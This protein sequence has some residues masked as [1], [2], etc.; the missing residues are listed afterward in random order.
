[1]E[2]F[3]GK[4]EDEEME[5]GMDDAPGE[6]WMGHGGGMDMASMHK[7]GCPYCMMAIGILKKLALMHMWGHKMLGGMMPGMGM[8]GGMGMKPMGMGACGHGEMGEGGMAPWRKFM[9][10]DEKIEK[11][12]KYLDEL[13]KEEKAV[14]EKITH[15]RS[16]FQAK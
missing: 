8:M 3:K 14:Q 6:G 10:S 7:C 16:K 1:M 5:G 9:S 15:I 2:E 12:Q 4:E 11:L 13:E